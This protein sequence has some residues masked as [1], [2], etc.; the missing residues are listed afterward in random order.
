MIDIF[1][2]T[3]ICG[4]ADIPANR[5]V[6]ATGLVGASVNPYGITSLGGKATYPM[7]VVAVG[8]EEVTFA[9][10]ETPAVGDRVASD[11]DGKAIVDNT[12]GK[13]LVK[14][15]TSST[16]EVLMR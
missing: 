2:D 14:K 6:L 15:V 5:F 16:V 12:T 4:A 10:G 11:A 7:D 9:D 13:F 3:L 1:K 8:L